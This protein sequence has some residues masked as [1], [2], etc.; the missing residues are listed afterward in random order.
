VI[1]VASS[2]NSA[3]M[4]PLGVEILTLLILFFFESIIKKFE[5]KNP[6]PKMGAV[7]L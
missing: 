7:G 6:H 5:I 2:Y 4:S 3:I 1:G